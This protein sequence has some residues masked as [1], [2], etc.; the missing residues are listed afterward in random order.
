[1]DSLSQ[2][3]HPLLTVTRS[4][5]FVPP[6]KW[7][8]LTGL[9]QCHN[10]GVHNPTINVL[11][12]ALL[13]RAFMC[14][15][16]PNVFMPPLGS[17]MEEWSEMDAFSK[18]LDKYNGRHWHPQTATEVVNYY[19]GAKRDLYERARLSLVSD[20]VCTLKDSTSVVFAKFE[21]ANLTKAPRCIQPRDP[22][23]N[24]LVG[25]YVKQIEHRIYRSIA[26]TFNKLNQGDQPTVIKGFNVARTA[27]ILHAKWGRFANPIC[28]GLDA[29][30]F[31]MHVTI[32]G[33]RMEHGVYLKMYKNDKKLRDL[34][35]RQ[36]HNRGR[37]YCRDGK[38]KFK[39]EGIRFSGDMNTALGNCIQMCGLVWTWAKRVGVNI[40][41][42]N[43]GDDCV[44]FCEEENE[45][46][47]LDGLPEWFISKGFRMDV[48]PTVNQFE[49]VEFCQ[50]HPVWNGVAYV[51]CRS[52]PTVL[53]KDSMCLISLDTRK[54]FRNWC[55]AVG[56]CGGSLSTGVPVMQSFYRAFRRAGMGA[57]PSKGF[58]ASIYRN[59][60]QAERMGN[61]KYGVREIEAEARYSFWIAHGI[62]P[63]VQ[64]ELE[65]YYDGYSIQYPQEMKEVS[66]VQIQNTNYI[67]ITQ[68]N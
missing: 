27:E 41:L 59:S 54:T 6:R 63:A 1:M 33:L 51:M 3:S 65:K 35:E 64:I 13:E 53:V 18:T 58:I 60:G 55:A 36:I 50:A 4:G 67:E 68:E 20:P 66:G 42:A 56:M 15:V 29:K 62:M 2:L 26:K 11:M 46:K 14:E 12:R 37:G 25:K 57:T 10:L 5:D 30:K 45:R 23:Y 34:L 19:C 48:E 61:L 22:R 44:I 16:E 28:I 52:L 7:Y 21:K 31:D 17:T 43:N 39:I 32:P 9:G 24:L 49:E 40:E 38:L 47:F 8:Q